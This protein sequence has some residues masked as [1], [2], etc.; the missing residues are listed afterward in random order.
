MKRQG[1]DRNILYWECI[2]NR[3]NKCRGRVKSVGD[4]LFVANSNGELLILLDSTFRISHSNLYSLIIL[5]ALH[6]HQIDNH[7]IE[8]ARKNGHIV[9]K[10]LSS[11]G[12]VPL[13][14]MKVETDQ[15]PIML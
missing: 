4:K 9:Y 7:R 1:V 6:N 3:N 2:Y 8:N 12:T 15:D 14:I 11:L 5:I 13:P 10:L